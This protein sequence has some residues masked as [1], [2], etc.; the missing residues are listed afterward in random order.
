M[1][2]GGPRTVVENLKQHRME[3]QVMVLPFLS[4]LRVKLDDWAPRSMH[5]WKSKLR[6]G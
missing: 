3:L 1:W 4:V 5:R 2:R 6:H